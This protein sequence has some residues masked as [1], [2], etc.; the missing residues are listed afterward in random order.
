M[1]HLLLA[2]GLVQCVI[3]L[4]VFGLGL[5]KPAGSRSLALLLLGAIAGSLYQGYVLHPMSELDAFSL[6]GFSFYFYW[7]QGPLLYLWLLSA[8]GRGQDQHLLVICL[9][10]MLPAISLVNSTLLDPPIIDTSQP[11][12]FYVLYVQMLA[13]IAL[14]LREVRHAESEFVDTQSNPEGFK[15]PRAIILLS[16]V[17]IF[18]IFDCLTTTANLLG[19]QA[20][21]A[22]YDVYTV[23]ESVVISLLMFYLASGTDPGEVEKDSQ[24]TIKVERYS[25]SQLDDDTE[26]AIASSLA[27]LM[28][29]QRAY[30]D[31]D[32]SLPRMAEQVGTTTHALSQVLNQR[33]EQN[34]Y[35]FVN[36]YRIEAA[37]RELRSDHQGEIRILDLAMAVGFNSKNT[38]NRAF[39]K[40]QGCTPLEFRKREGS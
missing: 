10:L 8:F 15:H 30:E 39:R 26:A 16:G 20:G 19:L 23:G 37:C 12:V 38:F 34:F 14:G 28:Q 9:H 2:A 13:Y 4:A 35:E 6:S 21:F 40:Y 29:H 11:W 36:R 7:S 17:G 25:S 32:L 3:L 1:I 22:I 18:W 33:L 31:P 24:E 5:R 27:D